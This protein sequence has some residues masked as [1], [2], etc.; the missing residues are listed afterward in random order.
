MT[1]AANTAARIRTPCPRSESWNTCAV[2][3]KPVVIVAGRFELALELADRVDR[4]A[5]RDSRARG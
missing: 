1:K 3:G 5:Q 2:P 4:L